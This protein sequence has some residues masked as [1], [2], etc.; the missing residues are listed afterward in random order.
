MPEVTTNNILFAKMQDDAK[1]PSRNNEDGGYDIYCCFPQR[2]IIIH[3]GE[4]AKI[5]SGIASVFADDYVMVGKERGSTGTSGMALR[6][7]VI[8]SGYRG[9]WM[10][11]IN[12]TTGKTIIITKEAT[13][14]IEHHRIIFYPYTKAVCQVVLLPVPKVEVMEIHKDLLKEYPS[15][16]GTGKLGSTDK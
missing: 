15:K 9:E 6:S 16:R 4:I 8:D 5:P 10:I 14:K 13:E 3:P 1:I 2:E 12:N 7:M 11:P